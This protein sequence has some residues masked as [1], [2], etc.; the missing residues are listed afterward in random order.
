MLPKG[1]VKD[2]SILGFAGPVDLLEGLLFIC[3][4]SPDKDYPLYTDK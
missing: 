3:L 2:R 1:Y 4:S